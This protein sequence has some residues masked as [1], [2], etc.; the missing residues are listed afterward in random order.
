M[1]DTSTIKSRELSGNG[2][3]NSEYKV[4]KTAFAYTGII[5]FTYRIFT[6]FM[7]GFQQIGAGGAVINI[8]ILSIIMLIAVKITM[9]LCRF[10]GSINLLEMCRENLGGFSKTVLGI[11]AVI[12]I[13]ISLSNAVTEFSELTKVIAFKTAPPLFLILFFVLI[14][15]FAARSRL[16][17]VLGVF[18][19]LTPIIIIMLVLLF[20]TSIRYGDIKNLFPVFGNS[21]NDTFVK[22]IRN[23]S[24]YS[25]FI[26]LLLSGT[27]LD[28]S[29]VKG[30]TRSIEI[31]ALIGA[32]LNI[33]TVLMITLCTAYPFSKDISNP[34]YHI[35]EIVYYGRFFQRVDGFYMLTAVLTGLLY[36]SYLS[37]IL[38][39]I[40][41]DLLK[42]K[43]TKSLGFLY[44]LAIMLLSYALSDRYIN[45]RL[46][47][48]MPVLS[49][50]FGII[51]PLALMLIIGCIYKLKQNKAKQ[52]KRD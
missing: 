8:V 27:V 46:N 35:I 5:L 19:V 32:V 40:S 20:L 7:Q 36:I 48:Y 26:L 49:V 16:T 12:F 22:G 38:I 31:S 3:A 29:E 4:D 34:L 28:K 42:I 39:G 6:G 43:N 52:K 14:V 33:V 50:V 47:S 25:D 13:I 24:I 21:F 23:I 11:L 30:V 37:N 15:L 10:M 18:S 44:A 41:G 1:N 45:D 9:S 51:L 2:E 17:A